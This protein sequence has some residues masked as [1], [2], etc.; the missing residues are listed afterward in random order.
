MLPIRDQ[1]GKTYGWFDNA[2]LH[3]LTGRPVAFVVSGGHVYAY[4]GARLGHLNDG[5]FCDRAGDAVAWLDGA[6]GG[7]LLPLA[8]PAP[9]PP[10]PQ[11]PFIDLLPLPSPPV[12]TIPSH[13]WSSFTWER[14]CTGS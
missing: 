7:P 4:T 9:V 3:D 6:S 10:V 1:T 2:R 13:T 8:L 11:A 12:P 14:F 5:Y